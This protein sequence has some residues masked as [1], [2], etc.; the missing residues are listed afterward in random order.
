VIGRAGVRVREAEP[1]E[2][3]EVL[4]VLDGGALATDIEEVTAGLES[5]DVL[6]AVATDSEGDPPPSPGDSGRGPALG[7]LVLDGDEIVAVAVRRRRRDQGIGRALVEAAGRRR[8][9]LVARFEPG[10][11]PFWESL[12]FDVSRLPHTDRYRG[13]R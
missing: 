3:A 6:V 13:V 10:V 9:R 4:N 11:C 8:D 2:R 1:T 7:A 12:G 5:G